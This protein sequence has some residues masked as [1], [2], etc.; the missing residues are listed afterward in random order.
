MVTLSVYI[1]PRSARD[2]VAGL[3]GD[4]LRVRLS[5]PPVEGAANSALI[6]FV[7]E[8][9]GVPA[10]RVEILSGHG[11]RRKVLAVAG[12]SEEEVQSRLGKYIR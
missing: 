1:V 11:S 5:A 9:L 3:H 12:L 4:A 7:A 2:E 10:R 8:M 6:A